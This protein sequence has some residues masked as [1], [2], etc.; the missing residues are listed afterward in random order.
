LIN[1]AMRFPGEKDKRKDAIWGLVAEGYTIRE[2]ASF[3]LSDYES[4]EPQIRAD[5][6]RR[7]SQREELIRNPETRRTVVPEDG[8][9]AQLIE[10][11]DGIDHAQQEADA[12]RD[13]LNGAPSSNPEVAALRAD[14]A[15]LRARAMETTQRRD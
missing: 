8:Y 4:L 5:M 13:E 6:S 15:E 9:E 11:M 10:S 14:A 12:L 1:L 7:R 3:I 2:A